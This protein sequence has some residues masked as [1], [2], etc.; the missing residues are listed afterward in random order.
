[1]AAAVVMVIEMSAIL[2][3][4][5]DQPEAVCRFRVDHPAGILRQ[6]GGRWRR[7]RAGRVVRRRSHRLA[8]QGRWNRNT[9]AISRRLGASED[10][11]LLRG[12]GAA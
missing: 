12:G 6:S 9:L 5:F 11:A 7:C 1:M 10:D 8:D 2:A 3:M 4:L